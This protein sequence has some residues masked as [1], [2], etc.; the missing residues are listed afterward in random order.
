[1]LTEEEFKKDYKEYCGYNNIKITDDLLNKQYS[2]YK[3]NTGTS[4]EDSDLLRTTVRSPLNIEISNIL[5]KIK[6]LR[7]LKKTQ[8][9]D[10][11]QKKELSEYLKEITLFRKQKKEKK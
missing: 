1:M 2:I 9:S 6:E 7:E 11:T 4:I 5:K 10:F 3:K 8:G